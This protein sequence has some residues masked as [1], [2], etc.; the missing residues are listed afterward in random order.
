MS[1]KITINPE[2]EGEIRHVHSNML[3]LLLMNKSVIA[4][5]D[6]LFLT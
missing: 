2:Y 3:L 1:M 6:I 4:S 5:S